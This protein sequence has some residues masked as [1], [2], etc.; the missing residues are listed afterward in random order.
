MRIDPGEPW[1]LGHADG[2]RPDRA[3]APPLQ[4]GNEPSATAFAQMVGEDYDRW[5]ENRD[6][7]IPESPA[8]KNPKPEDRAAWTGGAP[9]REDRHSERDWEHREADAEGQ[10]GGG[11]DTDRREKQ[12]ERHH[13][14]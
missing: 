9:E 13:P 10:H 8:G 3:R 12:G 6:W 4:P 7:R 11:V 14:T 1:D 2:D 5:R